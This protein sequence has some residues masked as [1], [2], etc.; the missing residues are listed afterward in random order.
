VAKRFREPNDPSRPGIVLDTGALLGIEAG[1]LTDVL[2]EAHALGIA[3]RLS[4]GAV[5]QAWRGG[6]RSAR[7]GAF[8]K[9]GAIVVALD[10]VEGRHVG[11]LIARARLQGRAKPDVVDAHSALITRATGSLVFTSDAADL[12]AYGVAE[13]RIRKV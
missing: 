10:A 13:K 1:R 4:G 12:A 7:L 5:A 11:E 6:P 8:L 3:V 2:A 9:K